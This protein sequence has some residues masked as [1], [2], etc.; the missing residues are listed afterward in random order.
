MYTSSQLLGPGTEAAT[1]LEFPDFSNLVASQ[2]SLISQI[3]SEVD[4]CQPGPYSGYFVIAN[5][6]VS[7]GRS[8]EPG[9][10]SCCSLPVLR[11]S[12]LSSFSV[13]CSCSFVLSLQHC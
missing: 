12:F 2:E 6:R 13:C 4:I 3:P 9:A 7:A 10:Q 11:G 5:V 1:R 8:Q